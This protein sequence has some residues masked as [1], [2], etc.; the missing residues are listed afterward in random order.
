MDF[1][2]E[3]TLRFATAQRKSRFMILIATAIIGAFATV[4][5]QTLGERPA[6]AADECS[7]YGGHEVCGLIREKYVSLGGAASFLGSPTSDEFS[8]GDGRGRGS[9]FEHGEIY[10][11]PQ[12]GAHEV[13]G[14]IVDRWRALGWEN[15]SLGFPTTD[16]FS[17]GSGSGQGSHFENGSIYSSPAGAYAV[18][19]AIR[20]AWRDTGWEIGPLGFPLTNE[21]DDGIGKVSYFQHGAIHWTSAEG[22]RVFISPANPDLLGEADTIDSLPLDEFISLR[23]GRATDNA[24]DG[25]AG[26]SHTS[27]FDWTSNGCSWPTPKGIDKFFNEA[28]VR[29]DFGWR[30]FGNGMTLDKSDDRKAEV[31]LRLRDDARDLCNRHGNPKLNWSTTYRTIDCQSAAD[32]LYAAVRNWEWR[33]IPRPRIRPFDYF[34]SG[35]WWPQPR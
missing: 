1:Y 22:A 29:H 20:D 7:S 32:R 17:V 18:Q 27:P 34:L 16:E 10:W 30:N 25:S 11:S 2:P 23:H 13:H 9:H 24:A 14:W 26:V 8:A 5:I 35:A 6:A 19:G 4:G 21:N 3:H 33:G 12:T 28:C 31:D 15:R